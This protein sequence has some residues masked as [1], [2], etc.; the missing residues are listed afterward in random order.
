MKKRLTNKQLEQAF[1]QLENCDK[2]QCSGDVMDR[3]KTGH[4]KMNA[5]WL[6]LMEYIGLRTTWILL[7]FILAALIN[8]NLFIQSRTPEWYFLDFGS[9][10]V[11][12]FLTNLPYGWWAIAF[13]L[14]AIAILLMKRF[15]VSF[16]LPF[17]VFTVALVVGVFSVGTVT[18]A[19]GINNNL[20]QKLVENGG[21][22]SLLAKLY[23]LCANRLLSS[24][25][26]LMGEVMYLG[27]TNFVLQAPDLSIY[28]VEIGSD[29]Q[30]LDNDPIHQ[31]DMVKMLGHKNGDVFHASHIKVHGPVTMKLVR[32]TKDC[33]DQAKWQEK[34]DIAEKRRQVLYSP[35]TPVIAPIQLIKSIY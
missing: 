8:L 27:T 5:R 22:D 10:G 7:V 11:N 30:L 23:C 17:K 33:T 15:S 26:A 29:T 18:F 28:T 4:V 6:V 1:N 2:Y 20:Y 34:Q 24:D 25:R 13:G 12:I 14:I 9:S 35:S 3:I 16:V 19:T 32:D 21:D 31:Y